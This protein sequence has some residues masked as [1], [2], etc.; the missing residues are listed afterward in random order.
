MLLSSS[1]NLFVLHPESRNGNSVGLDQTLLHIVA[2]LFVVICAPRLHSGTSLSLLVRSK[3]NLSI[4][5]LCHVQR[6]YFPLP[7]V[8]TRR[9]GHGWKTVVYFSGPNKILPKRMSNSLGAQSLQC[10]E[11]CS[12]N[13]DNIFLLA[14]HGRFGKCGA[15]AKLTEN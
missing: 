13:C 5:I 8:S 9:R 1:V 12:E 6:K 3:E 2:L 11:A 15:S 10:G 7:V 4:P 14:A